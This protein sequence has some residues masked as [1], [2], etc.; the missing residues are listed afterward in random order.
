MIG[1]KIYVTT[2]SDENIVKLC[3]NICL[4]NHIKNGGTIRFT[5]LYKESKYVLYCK[6]NGN[7]VGYMYLS[8]GFI[9]GNDI[10]I[11]QIAVKKDMQKSGI[12]TAMIKYLKN[13]SKNFK[14]ITSNVNPNNQ[15][16]IC[17]HQKNGFKQVGTNEYGLTFAYKTKSF[18]NHNLFKCKY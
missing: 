15:M 1:L 14:F 2:P 12:G 8:E 5:E 4:Q 7:I 9:F 16:S 13:H 10:Y 17:F 3:E 11:E 18:F 6:L